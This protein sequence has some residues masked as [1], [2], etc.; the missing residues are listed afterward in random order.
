MRRV[1]VSELQFNQAITYVQNMRLFHLCKH[2][3][4]NTHLPPDNQKL[5]D[6]SLMANKNAYVYTYGCNCSPHLTHSPPL[7]LPHKQYI[8]TQIK[9]AIA[10]PNGSE[11]TTNNDYVRSG[12]SIY[13]I[14][15]VESLLFRE[16][17]IYMFVQFQY[18]DVCI[19]FWVPIMGIQRRRL[20]RE[21]CQIP[22]IRQ[23]DTPIAL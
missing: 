23:T 4:S 20:A 13:V 1:C 22:K 5:L 6:I 17:H 18:M 16:L 9:C 8:Q 11:Q 10:S 15:S 7:H 21:M 19:C 3:H 12:N 2:T 14:Q